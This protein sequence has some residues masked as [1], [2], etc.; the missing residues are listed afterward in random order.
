VLVV[1]TRVLTWLQFGVV[2]DF[3]GQIHT[4]DGH[5]N[6]GEVSSSQII[7]VSTVPAIN[8]RQRTKTHFIDSN[9]NAQRYCDK[10]LRP[11]VLPFISCHHLMFQHANAQPHVAKICI[12]FPEAE[13]VPVLPWPAYSPDV[14]RRVCLVCSGSMCTTACSSSRQYPAALYSHWRGVG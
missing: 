11:I 3:I 4:F 7:P 12:Q 2:T 9:L 5:W 6:A 1:L 13:N 8:Y 14:P 10:I